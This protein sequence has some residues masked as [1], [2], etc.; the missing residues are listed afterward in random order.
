MQ[1]VLKFKQWLELIDEEDFPNTPFGDFFRNAKKD[2]KLPNNITTEEKL[3]YYFFFADSL[4]RS[5]IPSVWKAYEDDWY[6]KVYI[7]E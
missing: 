5:L 7:Y 6:A 2:T 3:Y 4:V 1:K